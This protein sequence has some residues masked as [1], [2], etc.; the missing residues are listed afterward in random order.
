MLHNTDID[1][2]IPHAVI[3]SL[4]EVASLLLWRGTMLLYYS[5]YHAPYD[6]NIV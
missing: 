4:A 5:E 2:Y 6:G 3:A 1:G